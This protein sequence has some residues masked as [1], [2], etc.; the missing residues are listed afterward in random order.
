MKRA[1]TSVLY[2]ETGPS[3]PVTLTVEPGE[4]FEIETQIN[5]GPWIDDSVDPE[6]ERRRLRGANPASGCIAVKGAK[7]GQVLAIHIGGIAVGE[8]GFTRFGGGNG[9]MPSWFGA[10]GVGEHS[11]IV[12][13][14]DG[15]IAWDTDLSLQAKPMVGFVGVA[16]PYESFSNARV[17][18]W[19]GN[20][21]VQEITTGATVYLPVY[22]DNALLHVGDMH[23]LQGDGEICGAGGIET[24][25]T[26][27]IRCE[28]H[29]TSAGMLGPRIENEAHLIAVGL[30]RPAEDA[31]RL[32]L[33]SLVVWMEVEYGYSRGDAYLLLGQVLEA[34]ATQFVNPVITYVAKVGKQYLRRQ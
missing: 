9:A 29:N 3:N 18:Y 22:V 16:P 19:G 1:D 26:V 13:I 21:D 7:P 31:F 11:R 23:A 4:E 14:R 10:S 17:G 32:A 28:L 34:R 30:A 5:A 8:M 12:A 25:G 24:G 2:F 33:E 20:F 6:G 27:R 15:R